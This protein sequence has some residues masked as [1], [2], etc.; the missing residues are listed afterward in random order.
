MLLQYV[1]VYMYVYI[2][3]F[4]R[5]FFNFRKMILLLNIIILRLIQC[6]YRY[7]QFTPFLFLSICFMK[8]LQF[9]IHLLVDAYLGF[10]F[11]VL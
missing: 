2:F 7:Q 8:I 9:F 4:F 3:K 6:C 5:L 10:P 1:F 11:F